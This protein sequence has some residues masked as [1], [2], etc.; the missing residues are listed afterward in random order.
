MKIKVGIVTSTNK[1]N[2][3]DNI[4]RNYKSQIYFNKKLLLVL[5]NNNI[6]IEDVKHQL[7]DANIYYELKI[8]DEKYNLG[9]C[10]NKAIEIMKEQKYDIF[11]KFDDDDIYE[12]KYLLEQ[13]FY[14]NRGKKSIVGKYNVPL[15][16]PERN[17]FYIIKDFSKNNEF[18]KFCRGSTLTFNINEVTHMFNIDKKHGSDTEFLK[19][20]IAN[21]GRIYVT[22]FNNYIWIRNLDNSKHNWK[23][24]PITELPLIKYF[25]DKISDDMCKVIFNTIFDKI[26]VLNLK[27]SL[28]NRKIFLD[29]NKHAS[30]N[31]SFFEGVYGSKDTECIEIFN[32]YNNNYTYETYTNKSR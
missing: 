12:K 3:I 29:N 20:H 26:Y 7:E 15:F 10:L 28:Y 19:M 4:I 30:L 18:V 22:S 32:N 31:F 11:T 24:N 9:Y 1:L 8:V 6:C 5:N 27:D 23:L 17:V 14:L 25:P 21:N 13:I 16:I 2:R